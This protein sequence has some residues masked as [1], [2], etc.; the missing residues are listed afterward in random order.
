MNSF[1]WSTEEN[2][3]IFLGGQYNEDFNNWKGPINNGQFCH[4]NIKEMRKTEDTCSKYTGSV[5]FNGIPREGKPAIPIKSYKD[6]CRE[7]II[8][9]GMWDVFS[10]KDP[11]N[12]EKE[13][14]LLQHQYI[15][16]LECVKRHV[17][18]IK[19]DSEQISMLFRT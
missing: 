14:D 11:Q 2:D 1:T 19:K 16:P 7:H 4:Q 9:N 3:W 13:W 8:R 5:K 12:K 6:Q 17:H 10:I 15:F 18:S